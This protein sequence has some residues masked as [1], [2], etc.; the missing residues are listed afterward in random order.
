MLTSLTSSFWEVSFLSHQPL[1]LSHLMRKHWLK[2][3]A[4]N[5]QLN[6]N[7]HTQY[8]HVDVQNIQNSSPTWTVVCSTE[9]FTE[10][11]TSSAS[12][13]PPFFCLPALPALPMAHAALISHPAW[14]SCRECLSKASALWHRSGRWS[15]RRWMCVG[16]THYKEH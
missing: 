7:P 2:S 15:E 13:K 3:H 1:F 10:C 9:G 6:K 16:L 14:I 4:H 11:R 12:S 5:C 8:Q